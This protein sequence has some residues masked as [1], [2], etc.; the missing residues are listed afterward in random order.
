MVLKDTKFACNG[1]A[2]RGWS[3]GCLWPGFQLLLSYIGGL[4]CSCPL[5]LAQ[6]RGLL[7]NAN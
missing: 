7:N 6:D 2:N 3:I 5:S 1:G 4:T